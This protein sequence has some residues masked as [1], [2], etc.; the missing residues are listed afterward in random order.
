MRFEETT[1]T[2]FAWEDIQA[3]LADEVEPLFRQAD[4]PSG[5]QYFIGLD[6]GQANDPTA[7]AVLEL[8]PI[9]P[10]ARLRHGGRHSDCAT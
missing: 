9:A 5:C 10:G 1:D 6:L 3:A 4:E 8:P 2:V 7:L